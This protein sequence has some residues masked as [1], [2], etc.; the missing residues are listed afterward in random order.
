MLVNVTQDHGDLRG[1]EGCQRAHVAVVPRT[2]SGGVQGERNHRPFDV[3]GEYEERSH[4]VTHRSCGVPWPVLVP[5][6]VGDGYR[7]PGLSGTNTLLWRND[8]VA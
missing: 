3:G 6:G 4:S 5:Q 1:E 7:L 8:R 2:R